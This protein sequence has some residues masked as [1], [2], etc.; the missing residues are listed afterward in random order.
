MQAHKAREMEVPDKPALKDAEVTGRA[1]T[2]GT[3]EI[4]QANT[5]TELSQPVWEAAAAR[6][7]KGQ[8]AAQ[9]WAER[10]A[11]QKAG[12]KPECDSDEDEIPGPER[13]AGGPDAIQAAILAERQALKENANRAAAALLGKKK[14][15]VRSGKP[16]DVLVFKGG[17]MVRVVRPLPGCGVRVC[18]RLCLYV[19]ARVR[20]RFCCARPVCG[21]CVPARVRACLRLCLR[22][23]ACV[24]ACVRVCAASART[25]RCA[26]VKEARTPLDADKEND[27]YWEGEDET[28]K[29]KM[30]VRARACCCVVCVVLCAVGCGCAARPCAVTSCAAEGH[31]LRPV[32]GPS[33]C[34]ACKGR[35]GRVLQDCCAVLTQNDLI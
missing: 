4:D 29:K 21:V 16:T 32:G 5:L 30:Q 18:L 27:A 31:C 10:E 14:V 9:S 35:Q 1:P 26:C 12:S 2:V 7:L 22:A 8:L 13:L 24:C 11:Q 23:C 15:S 25:K 6:R 17:G 34:V 28:F 20:A 3:N 33:A 19:R